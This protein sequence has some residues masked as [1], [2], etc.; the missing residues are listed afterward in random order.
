MEFSMSDEATAPE[1]VAAEAEVTAPEPVE[2]AEAD[3][4]ELEAESSETEAEAPPEEIEFDF[5]GNKF[6]VP[7]G[8][9]PDEIADQ[10]DKF[11][12]GTWSDYTRKSQE[13]AEVRKS[14]EARAQAVAKLENLNG[15]VLSTY[16]KGLQIKAEI[17]QLRAIDVNALWQSNPDQARRV[18]DL[19]AQ[20]SAEFNATVNQV[21]QLENGLTQAQEA[22]AARRATEGEALL[23]RRIK[24]FSSKIPEII[25]YVADSYG[26]DKSHAAKVWRQDPATA[27]MAYKAM[28]FDRMQSA[29]KKPAS[30]APKTAAPVTAMKAKGASPA[31]NLN[32]SDPAVMAKYLRAGR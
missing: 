20:K 2:V 1:G 32:L 8:S 9:I 4:I 13:V 5:G 14:V 31:S 6:K 18:S 24:G 10:L 12:K 26:I 19:M 25:D 15:E 3:G 28:M 27:E 21:A 23:E 29:G 17:E 11:T 22:E 16:S 7:K 30:V